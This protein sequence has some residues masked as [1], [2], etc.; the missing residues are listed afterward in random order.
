MEEIEDNGDF[1]MVDSPKHLKNSPK[2]I[3]PESNQSNNQNDLF[4]GGL[5]DQMGFDMEGDPDDML[6]MEE[7]IMN[8]NK[9]NQGANSS[10]IP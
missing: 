9:G 10:G 7:E 8:A 4:G 3:F 1:D 5:G 6:A 2:N